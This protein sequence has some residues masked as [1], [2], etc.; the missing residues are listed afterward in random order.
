MKILRFLIDGKFDVMMNY[1]AQQWA[2]DLAFSVLDKLPYRRVLAPCGFSGLHDRS[3]AGYFREMP[4]VLR[5]YDRLVFH[6]T[7]YRDAVFAKEHGATNSV[8]IPNGASA[9]EFD[10]PASEFRRR[11][12]VPADRPML[13][14]VGSHT[15]VKGHEAAIAAARAMIVVV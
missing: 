11:H 10:Q 4:A 12:G 15:G 6:S 14:T 5:R 13:L 9:A 2:T 8:T 1:A 7:D 3:Y